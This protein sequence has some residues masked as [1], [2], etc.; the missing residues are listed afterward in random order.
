M[1]QSLRSTLRRSAV[2]APWRY[3]FVGALCSLP[4]G[5]LLDRLPNSSATVGGSIMLLGAFLAGVIAVLRSTDPAA[6]GLRAGFIGGAVAVCTLAM[7]VVSMAAS[8]MAAWPLSRVAFWVV[9]SGFVLC[10]APL[11]GLVC[12]RIGGGVTNTVVSRLV[13]GTTES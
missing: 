6:S 7:R 5:A 4:V 1:T 3:A 10:V 12:G 2:S 9:A 8:D 13:S 11:F